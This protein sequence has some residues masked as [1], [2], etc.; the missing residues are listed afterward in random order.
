MFISY[1][2]N[3][4]DVILWRALNHVENGVYVDVGA[5]DP[6][7]DSVTKAFYDVGWHGINIEPVKEWFGKLENDRK[8]DI[9]LQFVIADKEMEL[10]FFEINGTGLSSI[11]KDFLQNIAQERGYK[12]KKTEKSTRTLTSILKEYNVNTIHFLKI[13]VEGA[14]KLVLGGLDL[15]LFRP[16]IIVIESTSPNSPIENYKEWENI[17]ISN[18]YRFVYFDGLNRYYV[19]EEHYELSK[20]LAIPPNVFDSFKTISHLNVEK[21]L[22]KNQSDLRLAQENNDKLSIEMD[23]LQSDLRLAQENNDKLSIEM[24]KLQSDLRLA[25]KNNDKLSIEMDQLQSNLR[26]AHKTNEKLVL[27]NHQVWVELDKVY[28]SKSF[29][30][31]KPIREFTLIFKEVPKKI[32]YFKKILKTK[33]F[34]FVH[35]IR[36]LPIISPLADKL[37]ISNHSKWVRIREK[38][39]KEPDNHQI[40]KFTEYNISQSESF[41]REDYYLNLILQAMNVVSNEDGELK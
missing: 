21:E 8:Q 29:L 5:M 14:E 23:K 24:G 18:S 39:T 41:D 4:E 32:S 9:N 7:I 36:M 17:L 3:F 33:I 1:A 6:T 40:S 20:K 26:L 30:I 11:R 34:L 25:Q 35:F 19:A 2:Q 27:E 31:T 37:K 16:W 15:R 13:D 22:T 10:D 38:F 12:I 28:H